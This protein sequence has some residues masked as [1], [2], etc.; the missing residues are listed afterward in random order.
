M[1]SAIK[2]SIVIPAYNEEARIA[3]TLKKM[4]QFVETQPYRCEVLVVDDGSSDNTSALVKGFSAQYS[5]ISLLQG[6]LNQGKGFSVKKGM[7][8][9][10]GAFR[11]F[12]DADLST[13]I[14]EVNKFFP[15]L[16][17]E[18]PEERFDI[19]IGSRR[20]EGAD[21]IQRQPKHR[22][23]AGRIF[24]LL[25]RFLVLPGFLDTQC[26]FKM[27]SAQAAETIFP[28][29]TISGFGFDVEILS[30]ATELGYKIS[31]TPVAWENSPLSKVNLF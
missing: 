29:Q 11:L 25:V 16:E 17:N 30:I 26:G 15:L 31:E 2:L 20:M 27:F 3:L 6:Q 19:V 24:S 28:K 7:L 1:E 4:V 22:E 10:K 8:A 18:N 21:L 12:S 13:P 23:G 9:A 14:D 5:F